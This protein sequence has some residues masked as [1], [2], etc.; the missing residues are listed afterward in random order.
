MSHMKWIYSMI[1]DNSYYVFKK[2]VLEIA[3]TNATHMMWNSSKLDIE[4]CKCVIQFVDAKGMPDY[5]RFLCAQEL[6][7]HEQ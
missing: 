6:D 2:T 1:Q 4:Y 3:Q 5:D 7:K